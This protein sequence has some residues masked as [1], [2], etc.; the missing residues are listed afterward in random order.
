MGY[1]VTDQGP[2]GAALKDIVA[3]AGRPNIHIKL[4]GFH[5]AA[6]VGWEYPHTASR[7]IVRAL[8]EHFGAERLHW[9]SD[10]P[11]VPWAMTYRQAFS[12]GVPCK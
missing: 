2:E 4:S 10:Y 9:G 6:P 3:S 8:Y 11:V 5:Y 1:P 7:Y 12:R